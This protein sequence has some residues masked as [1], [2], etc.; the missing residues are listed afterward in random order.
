MERK[1]LVALDGSIYGKNTLNYLCQLFNNIP[2]IHLHLLTLIPSS[3]G[4]QPSQWQDQ[5]D[6]MNSISPANRKK[7]ERGRHIIQNA[8]QFLQR[9]G[10][11]EQRITSA[12]RFAGRSIA[13]EIIAEARQG[14]YDALV[15]G[16]RGLGKL[17]GWI[18]GSVSGIVLEKCSDVPIWIVDGKVDSKNFLVPVDGSPHCLKAVDHISFILKDHPFAEITL[19]NSKAF[20]TKNIEI[21][22]EACSN[23]M[24]EE[25]CDIHYNKPES[26]F[27]AP[28]QVLLDA[29]FPADRI[30][31]FQTSKG[32]YP[33]RQIVRQALVHNFGT[34]VMGRREGF[35]K[36]GVFKGV[37]DRV[38]AMA[39]QVAIWIV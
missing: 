14:L 23:Y 10:V 8:I 17:E 11:S 18:M 6:F 32:I 5:A 34:I 4:P 19:F 28:K 21:D 2:D 39:E 38:L 7:K 29:G 1:V 26:L 16:R 20:F 36:K 15:I 24:G 12:V 33:S 22:I 9:N 35:Y 27:S 31:T 30:H 37:S 3:G 13:S 25:W